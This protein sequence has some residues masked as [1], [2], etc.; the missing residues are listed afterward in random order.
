MATKW[1]KF[2]S[3]VMPEVKGCPAPVVI[4]AIR[5]AAREF[6][7][8]T[9]VWTQVSDAEIDKDESIAFIDIPRNA[10]LVAVINDNRARE[11]FPYRIIAKSDRTPVELEQIAD[12]TKELSVRIAM[13]PIEDAQDCPD[14]LYNDH[15]EAIAHGA[16]ARLMYDARKSWGHPELAVVHHNAFRKAIAKEKIKIHQ[17]YIGQTGRV[18]ARR[19]A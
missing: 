18:R 14:F 1:D 2:F 15:G 7:E 19:F 12:T 6:C 3:R 13:K 16:K 11:D 4:Q 5:D 8:R 17:G 9:Y 10:R